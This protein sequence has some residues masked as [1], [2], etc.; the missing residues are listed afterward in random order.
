MVNNIKSPNF[1]EVP[2][3]PRPATRVRP[4]Q[5]WY[6]LFCSARHAEADRGQA[7]EEIASIVSDATFRERHLNRA[8]PGAADQH[9]GAVRPSR[10]SRIARLPKQVVKDAGLQPQ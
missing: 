9:A 7:G 6:G 1:P 5:S 4:S 2:P 8:Q 3:W 10:S